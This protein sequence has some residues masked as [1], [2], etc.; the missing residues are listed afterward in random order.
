MSELPIDFNGL[1]S[2]VYG[3]IRLR[4]MTSLQMFGVLDFTTLRKRL[5]VADGALGIHLMKLE[6]CGYITCQKAFVVRRPMSNYKITA[7]GRKALKNYL[8]SMQK[9]IEF[10]AGSAS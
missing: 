6:E 3:P 8:A 4:V 7:A 10:A 9:L 1:D 2:N 5:D